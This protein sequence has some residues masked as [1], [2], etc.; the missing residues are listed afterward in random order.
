MLAENLFFDKK[1]SLIKYYLQTAYTI[2]HIL[3][4]NEIEP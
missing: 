1:Q 4:E 2:M 3:S